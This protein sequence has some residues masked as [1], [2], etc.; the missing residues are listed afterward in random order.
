MYDPQTCHKSS[1]CYDHSQSVL[2]MP[3]MD[4]VTD[5][6]VL[7]WPYR[8]SHRGH[9]KEGWWVDTQVGSKTGGMEGANGLSPMGGKGHDSSRG[10]T[11]F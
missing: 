5:R 4:T 11:G 8:G 1:P 10:G 6:P 2:V 3:F 9:T 7:P